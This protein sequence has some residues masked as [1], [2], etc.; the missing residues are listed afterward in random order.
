MN[1][2]L[3]LLA[4]VVALALPGC[5]TSPTGI[6][7]DTQIFQGTVAFQGSVQHDFVITRAG[8][9]RF[10]A[11]SIIAEPELPEGITASLGF[12]LGEPN[13]AGECAAT[14]RSVIHET[15]NLSFGLQER[16]YCIVLADNGTFPEDSSRTYS[17][18]L[19]PS[20]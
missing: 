19:R 1:T 7:G 5:D 6:E 15:S 13:A 3:T 8:G 17:I 10:Q 4:I 20:E 18:I 14:F 11:E 2:R 16:E 9:V 12:G